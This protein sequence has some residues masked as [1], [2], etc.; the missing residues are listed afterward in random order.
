M[1]GQRA[2][3]PSGAG[4][5]GRAQEGPQRHRPAV[6]ADHAVPRHQFDLTGALEYQFRRAAVDRNQR[7]AIATRVRICDIQSWIA[8]CRERVCQYMEISGVDG[9]GTKKT[10]NITTA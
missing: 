1:R 8:T 5:R 9:A 2:D 6:R 4:Q 10:T 7:A 3:L